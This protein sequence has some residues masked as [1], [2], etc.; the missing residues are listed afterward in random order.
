MNHISRFLSR[1]RNVRA[2]GHNRWRACCAAHDDQSPSLDVA[3][4]DEGQ[5]IFKCRAG[6]GPEEVLDAVGMDFADLYPP[7]SNFAK[8]GRGLQGK[9]SPLPR[10]AR[11][12]SEERLRRACACMFMLCVQAYPEGTRERELAA[13]SMGEASEVLGGLI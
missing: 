2:R 1:L 3:V 11:P 4:G 12:G 13:L 10:W 9:R 8:T 5:V 6:C 7:D